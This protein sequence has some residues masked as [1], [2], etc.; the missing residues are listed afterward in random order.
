M[1]QAADYQ[2]LNSQG[3]ICLQLILKSR[4]WEWLTV[5]I[6]C[7]VFDRLATTTEHGIYRLQEMC[8]SLL[9]TEVIMY[10]TRAD[11]SIIKDKFL[12]LKSSS[13]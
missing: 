3:L 12:Q 2:S 6:F 8:G 7:M 9:A 10:R 1:Y 11:V 5:T 4:G 13:R